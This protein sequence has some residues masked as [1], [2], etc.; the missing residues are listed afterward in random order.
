MS[1]SASRTGKIIRLAIIIL[2][3]GAV[4]ALATAV[5]SYRARKWYYTGRFNVLDEKTFVLTSYP[6]E[7]GRILELTIPSSIYIT[8]PGGYG[9]YTIEDTAELSQVEKKD[10]SLL[11]NRITNI[12]REN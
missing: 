6:I 5:R 9:Q 7:D 4:F 3:I 12:R 10:S 1:T 11:K 2:F 8:V